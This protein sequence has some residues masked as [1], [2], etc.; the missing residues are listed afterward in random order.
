MHQNSCVS[1]VGGQAACEIWIDVSVWRQVFR[2]WPRA[3]AAAAAAAAR[4]GLPPLR[5]QPHHRLWLLCCYWSVKF[6]YAFSLLKVWL[7]LARGHQQTMFG[8]WWVF[9]SVLSFYL[10]LVCA[11]VLLNIMC[12]YNPRALCQQ[13]RKVPALMLCFRNEK[14]TLTFRFLCVFC[15]KGISKVA[16]R[17]EWHLFIIMFSVF[18][19]VLF[20]TL[21]RNCSSHPN[22]NP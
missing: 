10:W 1:C 19:I 21:L 11:L 8:C 5:V 12:G 6:E 2:V 14:Y 16:S 4:L 9:F 3:A 18:R 17:S 15:L 7:V 22:P 20:L 13:G